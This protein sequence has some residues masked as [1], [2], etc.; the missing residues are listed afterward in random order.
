M[1]QLL[2]SED[3]SAALTSLVAACGVSRHWREVARHVDAEA[4]LHFDSLEQCTRGRIGRGLYPR[5]ARFRQQVR[6]ASVDMHKIGCN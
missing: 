5:E 1:A 3:R 2:A 4:T 6:P